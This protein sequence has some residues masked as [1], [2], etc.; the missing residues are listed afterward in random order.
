MLE[1]IKTAFTSLSAVQIVLALVVGFVCGLFPIP[2]ITT[3]VVAVF[4]Q[5]LGLPAGGHIVAQAVNFAITPLNVF[6][7]PYQ[8][9]GGGLIMGTTSNFSECIGDVVENLKDVLVDPL[10]T[11]PDFATMFISAVMFWSIVCVPLGVV[12]GGVLSIVVSKLFPAAAQHN[13][14]KKE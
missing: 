11:I 13:D 12:I 5:L 3:P 1:K 9:C 7:I 2:G 6:G 10:G 4:G 14:L 8:S